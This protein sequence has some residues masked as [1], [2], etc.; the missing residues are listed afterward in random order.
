VSLKIA[1]IG[2]EST[3][4]TSLCNELSIHYN[5][6]WVPEYARTYIETLKRNYTFQDVEH[7]AKQ[8]YAQLN[9]HY[10]SPIVFFDTE[11]IITKVWFDVVFNSCPQWINE[12][13]VKSPVNYY[14]LC[15][16]DIEWIADPVREN[17]G[18]MRNQLH[19]KYE[20]LLKEF[21]LPYAIV[22]GMGHDRTTC[23]VRYIDNIS[24]IGK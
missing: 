18:A 16:T 14:L 8:Q 11:L 12:A 7:I 21:M 6:C 17:G 4:K 10:N 15:S 20:E 5:T 19:Q 23:A 13:I 3:G 22:T 1:L 9:A 2:A 24:G